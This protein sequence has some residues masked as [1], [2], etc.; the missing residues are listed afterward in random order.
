MPLLLVGL[1]G[2]FAWKVRKDF[3]Q[4]GTPITPQKVDEV[5]NY[6]LANETDNQVLDD[7]AK[8]LINMGR[9]SQAQQLL[10]KVHPPTNQPASTNIVFSRSL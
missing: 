3:I 9:D 6:A 2:V 1:L 7:F 5:F 4:T 8:Q 10:A